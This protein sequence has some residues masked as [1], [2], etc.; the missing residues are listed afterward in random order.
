MKLTVL[1]L[2]VAATVHASSGDRDEAFQSCVSNRISE[3]C[4]TQSPLPLMLRLTGWT[5][6]DDCKYWCTH[7]MTDRAENEG[8]KPEQ[9]YGKWAFW[10]FL[11]MQ[12]PASVLF[13]LMNLWAHIRGSK[14]LRRRIR[15]DHPMRRYYLVF[16]AVSTNSWIWS[17]VFHTRGMSLCTLLLSRL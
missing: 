11:G 3:Y 8:R 5:C 9:F 7:I 13:S 15:R 6:E 14:K 16:T 12:E 1:L 2:A 17:A 4:R 10:R